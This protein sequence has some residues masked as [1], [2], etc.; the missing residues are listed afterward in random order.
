M[1]FANI[2]GHTK[3][4]SMLQ[5]AMAQKRVGHS[6]IFSGLSAIGKKTLALEFAQAQNCENAALRQD[7]CGQ[8]PSCRKTTHGSHPDI[9]V[10]QAQTQ[11][12]RIDDVRCQYTSL[13]GRS[14]G[15]SVEWT[16][17]QPGAM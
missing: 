9:H 17:I 6:Y 16:A 10:L 4:I 15:G 13:T 3:Q 8:C 12:I 11:F 5:K 7:A 2:Y 14:D 1:S